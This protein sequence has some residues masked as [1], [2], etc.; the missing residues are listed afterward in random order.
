LQKISKMPEFQSALEQA[1][2]YFDGVRNKNIDEGYDVSLPVEQWKV[3]V[4]VTLLEV[5]EGRPTTQP[6]AT[7]NFSYPL[8]AV[9]RTAPMQQHQLTAFGGSDGVNYVLGGEYL[10]QAGIINNRNFKRYSARANFDAK[11]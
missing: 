9:L 11:L 1:Q 3:P 7:L 2:H 5:L 8:D 10:D 6:G 4:P